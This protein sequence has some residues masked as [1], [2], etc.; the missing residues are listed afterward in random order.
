MTTNPLQALA[1][2][3]TAGLAVRGYQTIALNLWAAGTTQRVYLARGSKRKAAGYVELHA[4]GRTTLS[5]ID[6]SILKRD[7]LAIL[8]PRVATEKP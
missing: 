4:D 1:D 5:Q 8:T 6:G 7:L 3:L 2:T